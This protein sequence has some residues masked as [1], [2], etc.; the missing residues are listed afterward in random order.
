MRRCAVV[1]ITTAVCLL[2]ASCDWTQYRFGAAHT[3]HNPGETAITTDNVSQ[4][5]AA[6]SGPQLGLPFDSLV[7]GDSILV[8]Y[9][10]DIRPAALSALDAHDGS[11]R[12][13]IIFPSNVGITTP[14][15][16]GGRLYV[17]A[18]VVGSFDNATLNAYRASDGALVWSAPSAFPNSAPTVVGDIVYQSFASLDSAGFASGW[19]AHDAAT[20]SVLFRARTSGFGYPTVA[21]ADGILYDGARAYDAS[22]VVNCGGGPPK[23]CSPLW[24]Y[25]M[26]GTTPA[27]SDGLV[28]ITTDSGTLAAFPAGGCGQPSC[29]PTWTA[30]VGTLGV[31]PAAVADGVVFVSA[32]EGALYAFRATG[33][34][35]PTCSPLWVGS[36]VGG[37]DSPPSVANG[38]VF[39]GSN[40]EK[41]HAF[42]AK[43]C[44]GGACQ[45]L[46]TASLIGQPVTTPVVAN[47]TVLVGTTDRRLYAYRLPAS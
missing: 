11:V 23:N 40:D 32:Q 25:T 20:G 46:W 10:D 18:R 41:L 42:S 16:G 45:P 38:I 27:V 37:A 39:A 13:S 31:S 47:G 35:A 33:C 3:G 2:L 7:V 44:I 6:W 29:P 30:T 26:V 24:S 43:G 5:R 15:Y 28:Y 4:L 8:G 9:W 21:V 34:G 17:P 12:W 14:S 1:V 22:G 36:M 19:E